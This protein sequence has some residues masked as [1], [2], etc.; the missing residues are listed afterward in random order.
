MTFNVIDLLQVLNCNFSYS[1]AAIAKTLTDKCNSG[2]SNCNSED[3]VH[4]ELFFR[5]TNVPFL[6][7]GENRLVGW[8]YRPVAQSVN[9]CLLR[10][11]VSTDIK[12][13]V[14]RLSHTA[15]KELYI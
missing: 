1:C 9:R 13:S 15:L 2:H 14:C 10:M 3:Y 6:Y 7:R 8:E 4:R 12:V 11:I 5:L